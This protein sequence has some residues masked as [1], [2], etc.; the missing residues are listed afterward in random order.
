M[1]VGYQIPHQAACD[2]THL[3]DSEFN[4]QPLAGCQELH[5]SCHSVHALCDCGLGKFW[6]LKIIDLYDRVDHI[7]FQ[8]TD[9][10][11]ELHLEATDTF[12]RVLPAE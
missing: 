3:S 10:L 2:G 9:K 6:Q 1:F 8:P 5:H 4:P 12:L 7:D 11:T